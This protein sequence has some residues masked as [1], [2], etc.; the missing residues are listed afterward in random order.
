MNYRV[1]HLK[2]TTT[3]FTV[4]A[5]SSPPVTAHYHNF[6][7][8]IDW[9]CQTNIKM[10]EFLGDDAIGANSKKSVYRDVRRVTTENVTLLLLRAPLYY[11]LWC[12]TYHRHSF[13][14]AT[15]SNWNTG[16]CKTRVSEFPVGTH[17][18][19][20][21]HDKSP[22]K[23]VSFPI[24]RVSRLVTVQRS[25]CISEFPARIHYVRV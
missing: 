23:L 15:V 8:I 13:P 17:R 9:Y 18:E 1:I 5:H 24:R 2:T 4:D 6:Y 14:V 21:S 7:M 25:K 16:T 3:T 20:V 10:S 22:S 12:G 19:D 11:K